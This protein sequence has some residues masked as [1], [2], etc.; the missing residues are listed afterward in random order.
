MCLTHSLPRS[1]LQKYSAASSRIL[2][3]FREDG[4]SS[5]IV[6]RGE[7]YKFYP[8]FTVETMAVKIDNQLTVSNQ[9]LNKLYLAAITTT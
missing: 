5:I 9:N 2:E 3:N 7:G 6:S 1:I 4:L 8:Q